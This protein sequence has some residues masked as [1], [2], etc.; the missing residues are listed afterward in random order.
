MIS[1]VQNYFRSL[2]LQQYVNVLLTG[3]GLSADLIA[4]ITFFGAI[5]TS[6]DG[7][8][9][10]VNSREFLAW[11]L[12]AMIYS[13]GMFNAWVRRRWRKKYGTASID[14]SILNMFSVMALSDKIRYQYE[15]E[16]AT[17]WRNFQRDFSFVYLILYIPLFF[18]TRAVTA[19]QTATGI[20]GSPWGDLV[21]VAFIG[22]PVAIAMMAITSMFDFAMSMFVGDG[23][24]E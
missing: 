9:F 23:K 18:Y 11:V 22:I 4:L 17:R 15:L 6:P 21:T 7:S 10:Y 5:Q 8:N 1:G 20:T 14:N 12:V 3:I 24:N 16:H 19:T 2:T 13:F